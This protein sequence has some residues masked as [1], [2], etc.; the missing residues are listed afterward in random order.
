MESASKNKY[1]RVIEA[2]GYN[3]KVLDGVIR[4]SF[5]PENTLDDAIEVADKLNE[6]VSKLKG[7]MK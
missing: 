1:S 7:I 6:V 4:I 2:C 5:S 3:E